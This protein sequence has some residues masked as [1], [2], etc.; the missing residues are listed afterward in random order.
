MSSRFFHG[1]DS[2]SESSSSEE[3][4]L[5]GAEGKEEASSEESSEEESESEEE[6]SSDDE[7]GRLGASRFMKDAASSDESD[8][9]EK[10]KIVKSAKDKRLEELEGTVR[11]VENAEKINDWAVISTGTFGSIPCG[12]MLIPFLEFDKMNRQ[13]SKIIQSGSIPKLYIKT[14]SDLEDIINETTVKQKST[15]KKMN[16]S[17][18]KGLNAMKQKIKK[19]NK[20]YVAELDKYHDGR[21]YGVRRGR[22]DRS[23]GENSQKQGSADR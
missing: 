1:G 20:D 15:T 7:G 23:S 6:S 22:R 9:E 14:I 11:L 4:E 16:A 12:I 17:N 2:D 3:E 8:D 13:V 21:I 5:Y 19:N 10:N 18:T